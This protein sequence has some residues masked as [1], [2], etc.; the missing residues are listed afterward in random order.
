VRADP[1]LNDFRVE[2]NSDF[3][4]FIFSIFSFVII[5]FFLVFLRFP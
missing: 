5:F 4:R 3:C 2:I 1:P